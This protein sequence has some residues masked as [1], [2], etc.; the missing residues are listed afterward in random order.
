MDGEVSSQSLPQLIELAVL[1]DKYLEDALK[2][3]SLNKL[4][5]VCF[6]CCGGTANRALP[7]ISRIIMILVT[8]FMRLGLTLP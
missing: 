2:T 6:I 8:A 3:N 1:H 7:K 5:Y 4:V